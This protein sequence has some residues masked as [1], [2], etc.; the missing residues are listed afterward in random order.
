MRSKQL[1]T[2]QDLQLDRQSLC[3]FLLKVVLAMLA[4]CLQRGEPGT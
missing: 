4:F 1:E 3:E 2:L